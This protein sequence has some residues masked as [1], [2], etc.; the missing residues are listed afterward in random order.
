MPDPYTGTTGTTGTTPPQQQHQAQTRVPSA[1]RTVMEDFAPH[2]PTIAG[3]QRVRPHGSHNALALALPFD[4]ADTPAGATSAA[5]ASAT[6]GGGESPV[7][8]FPSPTDMGLASFAE[9]LFRSPRKSFKQHTSRQ[10][11]RGAPSSPGRSRVP[12]GTVSSAR[13]P[14]PT[15]P[16]LGM[17]RVGGGSASRA[18]VPQS[19]RVCKLVVSALVLCLL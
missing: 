1:V 7:G 19:V 16:D 6:V 4:G 9:M 3:D 8:V 10:S 11:A 13:P 5:A 14:S 17:G 15:V 12:P 18:P 2:S